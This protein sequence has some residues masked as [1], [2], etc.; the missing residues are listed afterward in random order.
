M[1][2]LG[3]EP[4]QQRRQGDAPVDRLEVGDRLHEQVQVVAPGSGGRAE[5]D[6]ASS[7]SMPVVSMIRRTRSR[8]GSPAWVAQLAQL[9]GQQ[10]EPLARL[11]GVR[12]VPRVGE[13]VAEREHLGRVGP[14]DGSLQLLG[15][16][17]PSSRSV[18]PGQRA[19]PVAQQ[20][21]VARADRPA[22]P[23]EQVEQLGVGGQVLEQREGGDDLGHLGQPEQPLQADDLDRDPAR[24][25]GVEDV[26]R[27]AVV[28]GEHA[29]LAPQR[30]G[31]RGRGSRSPG[32]ASQA[33]SS[34]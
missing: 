7:T 27:M 14:F 33:S 24:R 6:E 13:G 2:V 10:G 21:Q 22:R 17:E 32:S 28:A 25:Q 19:R 31:H 16:R 26:G 18:A 1:L 29:D 8:S 23:V 5:T 9:R 30:L 12:R 34:S 3:V 4:G 11:L 15:D 20:R